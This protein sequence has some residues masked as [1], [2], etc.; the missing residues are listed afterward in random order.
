MR[1]SKMSTKIVAMLL[2]VI[3]LI[4][5]LPVSAIQAIA[6]TEAQLTIGSA[7]VT[8]GE[9]LELVATLK[10]APDVKS[11]AISN[12]TFDADKMTLTNVEWLC[13]AEIKNWNST[14][15]RGV[16]T[17]GENTDA[18]GP[19]L[20][21]TF[22]INSSVEDSD[23]VISCDVILK[24]MDA[25][26]DEVSVPATV[27]PGNVEIRNEIHGDMDSN[28]KKNSD[29]AV[30]L[31]YHTLFGKE[32]YPIKQSG[33]IDGNGKT[34]SND[35]VY[36]LY[37]VLF[38]EDEYPLGCTHSLIYHEETAATCLESGNK[39]YWECAKCDK[40][41][42]DQNATEVL[43]AAEVLVPALGHTIVTDY[44]VPPT[45]TETGLTEGSHCSTC[46][47][48]E[49]AQEIIPALGVK[50]HE[51]SYD[52]ANGDPYLEKLLKDGQISNPNL[53]QYVE[54]EG[55]TLKNLSVAGY[56][57]KGW[58]DVTGT[59]MTKIPAGSTD[60][61]ELYATWEK[62]VYTVQYKSS[63]F[64][65][66][67]QDTY[68]VDT[69]L[70]LP[71]P[72]LSNYVFT[73]WADE[74][75]KLY[76]GTTIPV[77]TTGNII[78][79]G[80][81]TSERNKTWTKNKLDAP[82]TYTENNTLYFVYEIGEIQ[83]VP[84][85][86][87]KDFGYINEG[88]VGRTETSKLSIEVSHE[89]ADSISQSVS[90]ATT[91]SSNWSLSSEWSE[92][93]DYNEEWAK[94]TGKSREELDEISKNEESNWNTSS[95][96]Y[97]NTDTSEGT[98]NEKGWT[99]ESKI[100]SSST[101]SAEAKIA[102]SVEST[103]GA[104]YMGVKAEVSAKVEAEESV[105][106]SKTSGMEIGGSN[107]GTNMNT[108]STS[109]SSGWNNESSYGGSKSS[110]ETHSV[111]EAIS[112]AVTQSYGYGKGYTTAETSG[113]SQGFEESTASGEEYSSSIVFN[114]AK[115][116]EKE[117][118]WSTEGA[119]SG[120]HRW[121]IA[122]TAHVFAVVGYDM[123]MQDYFVY[124]FTVMDDETHEFEDYSYTTAKFN[125]HENGVISFEIPFEV[126]EIVAE[127]TA[128]T[129]GLKVN[130]ATGMVTGYVGEDNCVVIP[131]YMNVGGNDVVKIKGI[132]PGAFKNNTNI[133]AV[134]LSDFITQ[135]PDECF[136]GCSSLEGV[137]GGSIKKIGADAFNGCTS[138]VD[139]A[140]R[141]NI[142]SVGAN[143]F[144]GVEN[145]IYNCGNR[146]IV[147]SVNTCGAKNI[148]IYLKY[149]SAGT[150]LSGITLTIPE[151]T[152]TFEIVGTGK[153]YK[154]LSIDS[155]AKYTTLT[156][157]NLVGNSKIPLTTSSEKV[158]L[159]QSSIAANGFALVLKNEMT[160]LSVQ[161][162]I[163]LY[164][165]NG[166]SV[167]CKGMTF[168]EYNE[169]VDGRLSITDT[170][171]HCGEVLNKSPIV[172]KGE[173][174]EITEDMYEKMLQSY[175][176]Y[177]DANGGTCTEGA[178]M[179][180]NSTKVGTL[181]T[182]TR[183]HYDFVG[184]Y[185]ADG[186]HVTADTVF[187]TGADVT[188]IATWT[189][190]VYT[191]TFNAN[192]GSVSTA[193]KQVTWNTKLGALPTP[194]R[195]NCTFLG[196][197]LADGTKV[198][199]DT[200]LADSVDVTLKAYWETDWVKASALPSGVNPSNKKWTYDLTTRTT[201]N[202]STAP[203][204]YSSYKDPTWVWGEYGSWS[205]WSTT[206]V[207][208]SDSRKTETKTVTD[209]EAYT[210]Y[211]YWVYRTS[212][213]YG[214]GTK[215]YNTGSH[216]SCTKY[217]E[218]NLNYQLPVHDSSI[219]TYGPYNSS[220]FSHSYDSY[221][222]YGG[223]SYVPAV[224]HTEYRYADRSKVYT[225]YYQKVEAKESSTEVVASDTIS[226]VQAWVKYI[227]K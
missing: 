180:A 56:R 104:E 78:L 7:S 39:S 55:M 107:S 108:S 147:E 11:M 170:V 121:I 45:A 130:Q 115:S 70:V 41:Y 197:Y 81:W 202:S 17:F 192:G 5:T 36:L 122:G 150:D 57:F 157:I 189:P 97:G 131:E 52:I 101:T 185:L 129:Q 226:N 118:T 112:E 43:S 216:G 188:V 215:N 218:I 109:T 200:V 174:V 207:S 99:N 184:W 90:K 110:T 210:N 123:E 93:V 152:E 214:Y 158:V 28:K 195:S 135:I 187:S 219:G 2:A 60:D 183:E 13:D 141:S 87:V 140:V 201:S 31:L 46:G 49:K 34:D 111:S 173:F 1:F 144:V 10:N 88:G 64:V 83:N 133:A 136:M 33:D 193:S 211:M 106:Q 9:N 44:A 196:W 42:R 119:V 204:G 159:N 221:W 92:S 138:L 186:T 63:L 82:I 148:S 16:L 161:S 156:K 124:T 116:E 120:Y 96:S 68:T 166:N 223:S 113:E 72:K 86:T 206:A 209:Q 53:P 14:Q 40:M 58:A 94:E 143:A 137:I 18:N 182:P 217:D 146:S 208:S 199:A 91:Q 50:T 54:S 117:Y 89:V 224:T 26:D 69:G 20:K 65:D 169:N 165:E 139:L 164:S 225:Y 178:R 190:K 102:A 126:A 171:L 48:V 160:E 21:M 4:A 172:T 103:V 167:L 128:Y 179:V 12:I 114:T 38:G 142:Q 23:I 37:H 73:G 168:T 125:D 74:N 22:K 27:V 203:T 85:Y 29:D 153:T 176:L 212:D 149:L 213:G 154:D 80:N 59:V 35:A 51:I 162:N 134:V 25:N 84:L 95:S 105:S 61:Y 220:M 47:Y 98:S 145:V 151:G 66:R 194:T 198:T 77:G 76:K 132:A 15:G 62:I 3:M 79:E 175:T 6:S 222:F 127:K 30:Y 191:V 177:F 71:T 67:A 8:P 100:S 75:G 163:V 155:D 32:D 181:P 227:I 19:V 24:T 205:S